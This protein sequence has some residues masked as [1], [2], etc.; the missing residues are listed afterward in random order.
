MITRLRSMEER[1]EKTHAALPAED[2]DPEARERLAAL[3]YVGSFVASASDS[4][5]GRAD[6]K[7]KIGLFNKLGTATEMAR[8][9][10]PTEKPP[11]DKILALL[12]QVVTEDPQVI[13]A[14]FMMG[15]QS[16]AHGSPEKAVEYLKKTLQLKPDYDIAVFNLAQAY[17]R[18]GDDDAALAGLEHYLT[19]DPKDPYAMYQMGEIWLDRG[20][21]NQAEGLFK[22]A[23]G[24]DP[25]VAAAKNALGRICTETR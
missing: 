25:H 21:L 15:T 18:L 5:T 22:R 2:V 11:T 20:D 23:L 19:L 8:D 13:D 17:R 7:D 9:R 16:L 4:R 24:I 12:N 14:W 10:G 1:F 6:P 3:G